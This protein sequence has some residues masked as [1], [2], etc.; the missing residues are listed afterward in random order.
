MLHF[1]HSDEGIKPLS[2][3]KQLKLNYETVKKNV[4][5]RKLLK[6]RQPK[7]KL[8]KGKIKGRLSLQIKEYLMQEPTATLHSV[9]TA[10][11]L[12]VSMSTLH[13]RPYLT[14]LD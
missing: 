14:Q 3:S 7:I 8:N 11:N 13:R 5:K 4:A 2:I 6:G 12:T 10:L 1:Q 9:I